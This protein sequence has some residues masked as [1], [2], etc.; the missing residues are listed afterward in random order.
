MVPKKKQRQLKLKEAFLRR[1]FQKYPIE[2]CIYETNLQNHVYEPPKYGREFRTVEFADA[3]C[4]PNCFLRP[5]IAIGKRRD[6]LESMADVSEDPNLAI[7][8]G[9]THA[10]NLFLTYCGKLWMSRMKIKV[11]GLQPDRVSLPVCVERELPKLLE[12]VLGCGNKG[13]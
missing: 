1:N 8:N 7:R 2:K 13:Y 3:V 5:C 9:R 4:C 12:Q 11:E 6:F 10:F